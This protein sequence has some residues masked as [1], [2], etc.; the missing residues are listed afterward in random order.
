[1][2]ALALSLTFACAAVAAQAPTTIDA[3]SLATAAQLRERVMDE[4]EE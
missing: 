4:S 2:R 3:E 1:M